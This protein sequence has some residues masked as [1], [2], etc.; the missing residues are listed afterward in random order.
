MCA[1]SSVQKPRMDLMRS[2]LP[3]KA[4]SSARETPV[5]ISGLVMGMFVSVMTAE[6]IFPRILW[7]PRAATVPRTVAIRLDSTAMNRELR[8]SVSSVPSRNSS[9][10]WWK[11]KPLKTATSA[12]LLKEAMASTIIGI[13]RKMKMM[14]VKIR[15]NRFIASPCFLRRPRW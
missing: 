6:R 12:P 11:V 9:A 8:S 4:N 13:Y 1:I 10:Y 5:T 2:R 3:A 14:T 7:M 15:L